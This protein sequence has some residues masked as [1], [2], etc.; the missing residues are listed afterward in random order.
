MNGLNIETNI[1]S[2]K[3]SEQGVVSKKFEALLT[4]QTID[5]DSDLNISVFY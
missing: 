3:I 1:I 5:E 2:H 4:V